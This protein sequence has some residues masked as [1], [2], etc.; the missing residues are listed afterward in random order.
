MVQKFLIENTIDDTCATCSSNLIN[1]YLKLAVFIERV[2]MMF[3]MPICTPNKFGYWVKSL[4]CSILQED[5]PCYEIFNT[6]RTNVHYWNL[7]MM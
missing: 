5:N 6:I 2:L 1:S 4:K 7:R 3:M